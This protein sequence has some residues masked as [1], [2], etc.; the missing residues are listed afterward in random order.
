VRRLGKLSASELRIPRDDTHELHTKAPFRR[1]DFAA[2]A[3]IVQRES[4]K[5][6]AI[7]MVLV[8]I[9]VPSLVVISRLVPSLR[10]GALITYRGIL[11]VVAMGLLLTFA[12]RGSRLARRSGL[13]CPACGIDLTSVYKHG[14]FQYL[15]QDLVLETGKCP[16]CKKQ[17]LDPAEVGPVS[18]DLSR[19][20]NALYIGIFAVMIAG[21]IAMVYFGGRQVQ[22]NAWARCRRLYARAYTASDSV[23]I[24][25]TRLDRGDSVGCEYFRR[26]HVP[27]PAPPSSFP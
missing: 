1:R 25:S 8:V 4:E 5:A 7:V 15:V 17:L 24:D 23:V 21:I 6:I 13:V 19:A 9:G 10:H 12:V 2:K 14:R 20:G 11:P 22:A 3:G 27:E 26:T 16:G 18:R